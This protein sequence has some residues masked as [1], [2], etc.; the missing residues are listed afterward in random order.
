MVRELCDGPVFH[1]K[2]FKRRGIYRFISEPLKF[3]GVC[4]RLTYYNK[5]CQA[6]FKLFL[7][8]I[9]QSFIWLYKFFA[10]NSVFKTVLLFIGYN[11]ISPK[12]FYLH[13]SNIHVH[14][15]RKSISRKYLSLISLKSIRNEDSKSDIYAFLKLSGRSVRCVIVQLPTQNRF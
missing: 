10:G 2:G 9:S 4:S 5:F 8:L 13:N 12:K 6:A 15:A 3:I 1:K 11:L 14:T 7:L